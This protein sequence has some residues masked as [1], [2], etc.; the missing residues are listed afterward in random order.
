MRYVR[1]A[2]A[3]LCGCIAESARSDDGGEA[4]V[5]YLCHGGTL[6][7]AVRACAPPMREAIE[8]LLSAPPQPTEQEYRA[9]VAMLGAPARLDREAASRA[10]MCAGPSVLPWIRRDLSSADDPEV[11]ERLA[12]AAAR[13]QAWPE[14][15]DTLRRALARVYAEQSESLWRERILA[16]PPESDLDAVAWSLV[17]ALPVDT[18]KRQLA[19]TP[20]KR[21]LDII[22]RILREHP[23]DELVRLSEDNIRTDW[24]KELN[25]FPPLDVLAACARYWPVELESLATQDG[26]F[27]ERIKGKSD[28]EI[29]GL[30]R[31]GMPAHTWRAATARDGKAENIIRLYFGSLDGRPCVVMVNLYQSASFDRTRMGPLKLWRGRAYYG[32]YGDTWRSEQPPAW[33]YLPKD[34]PSTKKP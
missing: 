21:R 9:W 7:E 33:N 32:E 16:P 14:T 17:C 30:T 3:L 26:S 24:R 34:S 13:L 29:L 12:H 4:L 18:L 5:R 1:F 27:V 25:G 15:M 23:S 28:A 22:L 19:L 6:P 11:H 20:E 2:V 31:L 8:R 10:L